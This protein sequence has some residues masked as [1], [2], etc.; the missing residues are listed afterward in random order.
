MANLK[1]RGK[2]KSKSKDTSGANRH[3]VKPCVAPQYTDPFAP[4]MCLTLE[5]DGLT[6]C[7]RPIAEGGQER[8]ELHDSQYRKMYQKYKDASALV[9]EVKLKD[10]LPTKQEISRNTDLR[11]ID[12]TTRWIRTYVEAIRVE[13]ACRNLEQRRFFLKA[14]VNHRKEFLAKEMKKAIQAIDH[15]QARACSIFLAE[16]SAPEWVKSRQTIMDASSNESPSVDAVISVALAGGYLEL[17]ALSHAGTSHAVLPSAIDHDDDDLI[18]IEL[19]EKKTRLLASFNFLL[20]PDEFDQVPVAGADRAVTETLRYMTASAKV[21]KQYARQVI[22]R[23]PSLFMKSLD[24]ASFR[25][26][27]LSTDFEFEDLAK[28]YIMMAH[29]LNF[30]LPWYKDAVLETL[31][32]LPHGRAGITANVG[33]PKNRFSVL[34]GWVYNCGNKQTMPDDAWFFLVTNLRSPINLEP[35]LFH[36]CRSFDDL[37]KLLSIGAMGFTPPPPFCGNANSKLDAIALASRNHLSL[38]GIVIANMVST[39]QPPHMSGPMPSTTPSGQPNLTVWVE[40]ETRAHILG[41]LSS[42]PDAF[43]EAF[44]QEV[45][46]RPDLFQVLIYSET[47]PKQ[48]VNKKVNILGATPSTVLPSLRHRAFVA[49]SSGRP[50]GY[51]RWTVLRSAV[52]LFFGNSKFPGYLEHERDTGKGFFHFKNLP[53]KYFII[54]D[55]I[56]NRHHSVLARNVAWA[57]LRAKGYGSGKY[58]SRKFEKAADTLLEACAKERLAWMPWEWYIEKVKGVPGV[59]FGRRPKVSLYVYVSVVFGL[60]VLAFIAKSVLS[61]VW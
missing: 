50:T 21:M 33:D 1:G 2:N 4:P 46:S 29:L 42:Q 47:G 49:P 32:M 24:K 13:I 58:S 37:T 56:P 5:E 34:G 3:K 41:A 11:S 30:G 39:H 16:N 40:L 28:F 7:H 22:F 19:Y 45:Q 35:L 17:Y 38:C 44:L 18:G 15:L 25:D 48:K 9:D 26:F 27:I 23:E 14:D 60:G 57:A 6:R 61:P 31:A 59:Q 12:H 53:V 36:V 8:C 52:D 43:T 55:T 10:E 20:E 54:L 51:G